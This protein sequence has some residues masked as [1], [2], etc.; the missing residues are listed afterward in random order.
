MYDLFSMGSRFYRDIRVYAVLFCIASRSLCSQMNAYLVEQLQSLTVGT[1][2]KRVAN[3]F[4]NTLDEKC[5]HEVTSGL[6]GCV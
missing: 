2:V 4:V 3:T 1:K 6:A 5:L